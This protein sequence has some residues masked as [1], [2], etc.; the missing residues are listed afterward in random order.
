MAQNIKWIFELENK[1]VFAWAHN[2]HIS[3]VPAFLHVSGCMGMFLNTLFGTAYYNIGFVF[4]Q[5]SFQAYCKET[6]K[7]Q[8]CSLPKFG[9]NTLTNELSHAGIDAFFI[10]LTT[11]DNKLFRKSKRA[12]SIGGGFA[13]EYWNLCSPAMVAKKQFDGLIFINATTC[14][15]PINR[16]S[17]N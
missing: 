2:A 1:P 12:Y 10:D 9:K 8:E 16:K 15:V 7:V 6:E 3:K 4:S 13:Q 5:G 14:A 11:T 17:A